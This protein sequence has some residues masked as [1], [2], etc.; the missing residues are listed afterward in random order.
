MFLFSHLGAQFERLSPPSQR[1]AA[2]LTYVA[3]GYLLSDATATLTWGAR[4]R[5][6]SISGG[7][8]AAFQYPPFDRGWAE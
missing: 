6:V 8:T 5:L 1:G 7:V 2:T 3:N 4:N